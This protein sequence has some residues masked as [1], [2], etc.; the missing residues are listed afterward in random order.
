MRHFS[1]VDRA[2]E[3][4]CSGPCTGANTAV[5]Y[6]G[7]AGHI[8]TMARTE[9]AVRSILGSGGQTAAWKPGPA[10]CFSVSVGAHVVA[11]VLVWLAFK[12]D[13]ALPKRSGPVTLDLSVEK[14]APRLPEEEPAS[15]PPEPARPA[16]K[17]EARVPAT[18]ARKKAAD[19]DPA[20]VP[21]ARGSA[22]SVESRSEADS[23][24]ASNPYA[25]DEV[26]PTP[27]PRPPK[28]FSAGARPSPVPG[29]AAKKDWAT[30]A[31]RMRRAIRKHLR[32]P[33]AARR[34]G[35]EGVVVVRF[36][37]QPS[38]RARPVLLK[39]SA[40]AVLDRAAIQ[41]V[42]RAQPLPVYPDWV[43]IPLTF[44]LDD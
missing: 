37:V 20:P 4:R 16:V 42:R 23:E 32:Y 15:V 31:G 19:P 17:R 28:S 27:A 30:V 7:K 33:D 14:R 1:A 29:A 22:D 36:R 13:A 8:D 34:Q 24:P 38:G 18:P 2:A 12:P 44:T 6:G 11:A 9:E 40:G 39:R 35:L 25:D 21:A 10:A 41:A 43:E 26:V 3:E 5:D